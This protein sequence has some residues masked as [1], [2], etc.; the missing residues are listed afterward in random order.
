MNSSTKVNL[1]IKKYSIDPRVYMTE[2]SRKMPDFYWIIARDNENHLQCFLTIKENYDGVIQYTDI[3]DYKTFFVKKDG[4]WFLDN[5]F[6]PI[7]VIDFKVSCSID[8][9]YSMKDIF[10]IYDKYV[11]SFEENYKPKV[12]TKKRLY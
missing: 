6:F 12:F 1:P 7:Q 9:E 10:D 11:G 8:K 2:K 5:N 4:L 3:N